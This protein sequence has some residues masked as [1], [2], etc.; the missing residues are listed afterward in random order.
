MRG[1]PSCGV[2]LLGEDGK[3][4][5]REEIVRRKWRDRPF[6]PWDG[7]GGKKLE[8]GLEKWNDGECETPIAYADGE[9]RE[10][11]RSRGNGGDWELG[12]LLYSEKGKT[13]EKLVR[14]KRDTTGGPSCLRLSRSISNLLDLIAQ[15]GVGK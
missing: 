10:Q 12:G 9:D 3:G 2:R 15:R 7:D 6:L 4:L 11:A 1:C 13:R 8:D 5:E 14:K